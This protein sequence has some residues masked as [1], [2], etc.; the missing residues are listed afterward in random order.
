VSGRKQYITVVTTKSCTKPELYKEWQLYVSVG[1]Q[2]SPCG[3]IDNRYY[4]NICIWFARRPNFLCQT[5]L[6]IAHSGP[7]V[8]MITQMC[9]HWAGI[10][11]SSASS[12]YFS[13]ES[14]RQN[15]STWCPKLASVFYLSLVFCW[16]SPSWWH[17]NV[18][19]G[20]KYSC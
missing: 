20:I 13:F 15:T 9:T 10:L 8:L 2:C 19:L 7:T 17:R 11:Y 18:V 3:H 14:L 1:I 6:V 16:T 4:G 5:I 12:I